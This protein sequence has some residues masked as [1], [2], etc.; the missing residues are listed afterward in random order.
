MS[1][2]KHVAIIMDGNGRWAQER[3][4]PRFW[5]HVRGSFVVSDIVEEADELGLDALTLFAFST[6]N[7]SRPFEEVNVLFKLLRKFI[8]RERQRVLENNIRFKVIGDVSGLPKETKKLISELE[9]ESANNDGLKLSFAFGYGG[10]KEIVDAV[11]YFISQNP[12]KEISEDDLE[13][14]LLTN[15]V[16]D[17]DLLIRTGGNHRISNFLLWQMAYAE[18]SFTE[19]MWPDL[20]IDEFRKIVLKSGQVERRFGTVESEISNVRGA[21]LKAREHLK[22]FQNNIQ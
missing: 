16:G 17:V 3:S 8:L 1:S 19:T 5:G 6:E 14:R 12:G 18:I 10:R 20:S 22:L 13:K 21:Q 7:W 2:I 11:N 4:R 9:Y 15:D